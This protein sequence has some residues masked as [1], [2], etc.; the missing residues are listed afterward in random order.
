MKKYCF[1]FI[2]LIVSILFVSCKS[3]K[4]S[5]AKSG[6]KVKIAAISGYF[7]QGFGKSMVAGL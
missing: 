5:S 4:S 7:G 2:V 6:D 3:E 1:I